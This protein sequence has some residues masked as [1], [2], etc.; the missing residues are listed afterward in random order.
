MKTNRC[1]VAALGSWAWAL[2]LLSSS[3]VSAEPQVGGGGGGAVQGPVVPG[4]ASFT[5]QER[6]RVELLLRAY[7]HSPDA[8][9]FKLAARDPQGVLLAILDDPQ[10]REIERLQAIDALGTLPDARA[11]LKLSELV[12]SAWDEKASKRR[13]H[14]AIQALMRGFGAKAQPEV[15]ALLDH[16]DLQVRMTVAAAVGRFGDS[17]GRASLRAHLAREAEP[18]VRE[19]IVEHGAELR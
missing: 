7:D 6:A 3:V 11:R 4:A 12:A 5:A 16:P 18:L 14:R 10:A 8:D 19:A 13:V 2:L 9:A 1:A 15:L 17:Q